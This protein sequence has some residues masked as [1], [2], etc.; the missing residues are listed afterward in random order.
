MR[1]LLPSV[2][3]LSGVLGVV[4]PAFTQS[5]RA[6]SAP[7]NDWY[8]LACSSD[9][10]KL[11][12]LGQQP[13]LI[14][15]STN[16]GSTWFFT[17]APSNNWTCVASSADGA[18]LVATTASIYSTGHGGAHGGPIYTSSDSGLTWQATT[19][20]SNQWSSVAS[21]ADGS[22]L[23]AAAVYNNFNTE[24]GLIFVSSN[25]GAGWTATSAPTNF[26]YSVACSA[27]GTR[28]VA[29]A[30]GI[31]TSTNSGQ[32][33]TSN[34]I[35]WDFS[36][37]SPIWTAV[38]SSA[39]GATIVAIGD[40][41]VYTGGTS[42]RVYTTTNSGSSWV[43]YNLP[44]VGRSFV[45]L[46]ADGSRLMASRGH[47]YLSSNSGITWG[48]QNIPGQTYGW[49][50]ACV[51]S[52]ADGMKLFLAL[53]ADDFGQPNSIFTAYSR[54]TPKLCIASSGSGLTLSWLVPSTNFV[55]QQT[56]DLPPRN[57]FAVT[58]APTLNP[59][60]LQNELILSS[61]NARAF[62]RLATP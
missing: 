5:W 54:P 42:P 33:W 39:D 61:S 30:T 41:T 9:G 46:S 16:S 21:S 62:F 27:D 35:A 26:W 31:F 2:M 15:A 47:L 10:T 48:Q 22:T 28:L 11:V 18:K 20:P 49:A 60:N 24:R 38:A 7:N 13:G 56:S 19:A 6:T 44:T 51:A 58:N 17:G 45:A 55:M 23:V 4:T 8:S 12:A 3:V 1:A 50:G 43:W 57:W 59:A 40:V 32:T 36:V 34:N 53:G 37:G 52:S 14:Y 25:S 29:G